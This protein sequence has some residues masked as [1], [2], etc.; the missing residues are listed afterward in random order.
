[1]WH[2]R[3]HSAK[4][5]SSCKY[6]TISS[7]AACS[8]KHSAELQDK[9]KPCGRLLSQWVMP[10][11]YTLQ[12]CWLYQTQIWANFQVRLPGCSS[13]KIHLTPQR[14]VFDQAWIHTCQL[15]YP[16]M[17]LGVAP[18]ADK[19]LGQSSRTSYDLVR[20][21]MKKKCPPACRWLH[22]KLG[23][24]FETFIPAEQ[25]VSQHWCVNKGYYVGVFQ[26]G[27]SMLSKPH[28]QNHT[29]ANTRQVNTVS[30][31]SQFK[32]LQPVITFQILSHSIIAQNKEVSIRNAIKYKTNCHTLVKCV[33][34]SVIFKKISSW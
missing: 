27:H 6:R 21:R 23:L 20:S 1:M 2:Y 25:P 4:F 14:L 31:A 24:A 16:C 26:S 33:Y 11:Q 22:N 17:L 18:W 34:I 12:E 9:T 32:T 19:V 8:H 10:R 15:T 3:D 13:V 28:W 7:A 5:T 30:P 29:V